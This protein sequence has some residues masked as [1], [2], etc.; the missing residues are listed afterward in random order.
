MKEKF[1]YTT[2]DY[3]EEMINYER[4]CCNK[5]YQ[6][7]DGQ[8]ISVGTER[9]KAPEVLFKP[10]LIGK[11]DKKQ[12]GDYYQIHNRHVETIQDLVCTVK[13]NK[14]LITLTRGQLNFNPILFFLSSTI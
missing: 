3:D 4:G 14:H 12:R 9:F 13:S 5:V 11:L 8:E 10:S 1:C 6:L 2:L 7:P